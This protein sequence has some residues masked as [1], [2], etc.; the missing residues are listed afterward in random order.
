MHCHHE[1]T[2]VIDDR[3]AFVGGI[4]LT[5]QSGDRFD[6]SPS[7]GP[8]TRSAGTTRPP[9]SKARRS[10]MSPST[11]GCAGTKS[12]ASSSLRSR[13]PSRPAMSSCR[14][15]GQCRSASTPPFRAATFAS[16]SRTRA[17]S[18]VRSGSSTSRTSSSGRRRS[19]ACSEKSS[20]T[21]RPRFP[22]PIVL[23]SSPKSGNDDTRGV[24][25]ELIDADGDNGRILACTLYARSGSVPTRSTSTPRSRIIDD[26]WVTL[27]SANLNEHSL[28]NDTEMNIVAHDPGAR[29]P[30]SAATLVRTPRAPRRP[31]PA[32]SDPRDRRTLETDQ[33]GTTRTPHPRPA[34]H[35]S[36]RPAA[37]RLATNPAHSGPDQRPRRRR[38]DRS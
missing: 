29:P 12:T 10:P 24:L 16:S 33:Q 18:A 37:G 26:R 6:S 27:G 14:S 4:D 8:R 2:I 32:R 38:L 21:R 1:K 17:R 22:G 20:S 34:A 23:P 13:R 5:S 31:D 9:G 30:N 35:A 25:A 3:V 15:C 7:P 19:P 11:S 28:F 36:A